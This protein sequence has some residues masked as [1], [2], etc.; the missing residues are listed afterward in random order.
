MFFRWLYRITPSAGDQLP[1][2]QEHGLGDQAFSPLS[3]IREESP[4]GPVGGWKIIPLFNVPFG[5][6]LS[7]SIYK[8]D[9][10]RNR[11]SINRGSGEL[12]DRT[13]TIR[14]LVIHYCKGWNRHHGSTYSCC[15]FSLI[16]LYHLSIF[17]KKHLSFKTWFKKRFCWGW[18]VDLPKKPQEL[19]PFPNGV[20]WIVRFLYCLVAMLVAG[21]T[22]HVQINA[23]Y[24]SHIPLYG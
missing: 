4:V 24:T 12:M 9:K 18:T 10:P 3:G 16:L 22:V 1:L 11:D 8:G 2:P 17:P 7:S 23:K 14:T 20:I 13:A 5:T 19:I 15:L 21:Q 6:G